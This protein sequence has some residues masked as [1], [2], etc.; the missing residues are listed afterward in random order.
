MYMYRVQ[1]AVQNKK[2]RGDRENERKASYMYRCLLDLVYM[3]VVEAWLIPL[4]LPQWWVLSTTL[5]TFQ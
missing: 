1:S 2:G 5:H 3:Y 4:D